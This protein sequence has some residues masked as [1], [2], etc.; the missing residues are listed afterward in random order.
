MPVEQAAYLA[1]PDYKAA[2]RDLTPSTA[3]GHDDPLSRHRLSYLN[4]SGGSGK[5][6]RAIELFRQRDPLVFTPTH[7]LTKEMR[8]RGVQ[9]RPTTASS[10][11]VARRSG[12]LKGWGGSSF[13]VGSSGTW[14][15]QCPAPPWKLTSSGSVVEA[16]RSSA[17]A[18]RDSR[19]L[20]PEKY[21]IAGSVRFAQQSANYYE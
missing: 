20:S 14:S 16:S 1:K 3:P 19:L 17:V 5:T 12:R 4:G 7:R 13:H 21:P 15:A 2:K 10:E 6:T 11:G 9:A 8:A 18:T